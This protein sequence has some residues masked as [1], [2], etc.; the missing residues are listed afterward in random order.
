[1]RVIRIS[2]VMLMLGR[3]P[4]QT[5][6]AAGLKRPQQLPLAIICVAAQVNP[7][8]FFTSSPADALGCRVEIPNP[9][10]NV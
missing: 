8:P 10:I 2:P 1:V 6:A 7:G 5:S 9:C 3:S 4:L